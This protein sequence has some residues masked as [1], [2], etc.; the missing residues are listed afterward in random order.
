MVPPS[1]LSQL[2]FSEAEVLRKQVLFELVAKAYAELSP[3][4]AAH[5]LW[6]PG[7]LEIFG[8]HTDYG[9]GHSLVTAVPRGFALLASPRT[10]G[11]IAIHDA[12]R[13]EQFV[14]RAD[15]IQDGRQADQALKGW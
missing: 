9:G 1:R 4:P 2:G 14:L 6:V 5:A 12:F 11:V 10:D 15:A 3:R 8:K 7:R 13:R